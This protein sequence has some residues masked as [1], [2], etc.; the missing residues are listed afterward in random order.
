[1]KEITAL[2]LFTH[3]F[4]K[5][6]AFYCKWLGFAISYEW[7]KPDDERIVRMQ[8]TRYGIELSL[9]I[10]RT[11]WENQLV[12][13]QAG[14]EY[15]LGFQMRGLSQFY[16]ELLLAGAPFTR[17]LASPPFGDFAYLQDPDGNKIFLAEY[18]S[19]S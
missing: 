18:W 1:M 2:T 17:E 15:L 12:G 6:I 13:K 19:E 11:D 10:P 16:N 7:N 9:K 5:S 3:D 8:N 4:D 14:E